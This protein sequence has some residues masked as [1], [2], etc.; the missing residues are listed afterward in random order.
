[1]AAREQ[2]LTSGLRL[3]LVVLRGK[4]PAAARFK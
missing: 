3:F 1:M 4:V 2:S